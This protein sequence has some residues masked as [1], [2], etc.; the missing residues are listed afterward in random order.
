MAHGLPSNLLLLLLFSPIC[1]WWRG[2]CTG[3]H[4][5]CSGVKSM[6]AL[7]APTALQMS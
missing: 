4:S 2:V 1:T 3:R 5:R 7:Y 6:L